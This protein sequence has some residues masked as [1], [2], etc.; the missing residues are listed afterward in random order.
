MSIWLTCLGLSLLFTIVSVIGAIRYRS[1]L[2]LIIYIGF[3]GVTAATTTIVLPFF[4]LEENTVAAVFNSLLVA[5]K[6]FIMN[7]STGEVT[8]AARAYLTGTSAGLYS[9][10]IAF[11]YLVAPM[12]TATYIFDYLSNFFSHIRV[13][14]NNTNDLY[15]FS[16]LN[17]NALL[18]AKSIKEEMKKKKSKVLIVFCGIQDTDSAGG[19]MLKEQAKA[20]SFLCIKHSSDSLKLK[21]NNKR[22]ISFL[23]IS[24]NEDRNLN[25]ALSLIEKYRN[26]R[27]T[28]V[29]IYIFST[30]PEAEVLLDS[31]GKGSVTTSIVNVSQIIAYHLVDQ[32][33]L[34]SADIEKN[35]KISVLIVGSGTI[36]MEILKTAAWCGQME[37]IDLEINVVDIQA[38]RS[39]SEF[40]LYCPELLNGEYSIH[41]HEVDVLTAKFEMILRN[42]C[43]DS[44]YIVVT[45]GRDDL[46]IKTALYLRRH[47]LSADPEYRNWPVITLL[48][49]NEEKYKAVSRLKTSNSVV[50]ERRRQYD[51]QPFGCIQKLYQYDVMLNSYLEKLALNVHALYESN[52]ANAVITRTK[53][54]EGCKRLSITDV[55]I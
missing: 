6:I 20:E 16:E 5:F 2:R 45:L 19:N 23:Q 50:E 29:Q 4:L 35:K 14:K 18:L 44:N 21:C 54:I 42:H 3:Y 37:G 48:V 26:Q 8:Q 43:K 31:I 32:I 47:Y 1:R 27:S 22:T 12:L 30:Q 34:Y 41:F 13:Q 15:L 51:L 9:V 55:Q 10:M 39:K 7:D 36:G 25:S 49:K 17:E 53:T 33:P 46:N 24:D 52:D 40:A 11:L 28:D 38:N